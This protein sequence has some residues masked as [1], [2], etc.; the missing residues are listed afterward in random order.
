LGAVIAADSTSAGLFARWMVLFCTLFGLAAMHTIGHTGPGGGIRMDTVMAADIGAQAAVT[1]PMVA[2]APPCSGDHCDGH[3]AMGAG[4]VCVA[5]LQGLVAAMLLT[6]MV[7]AA[8]GGA[9][10]AWAVIAV[11]RTAPRAPPPRRTGLTIASVTV[12]RI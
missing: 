4:E 12:L 6:L 8:L 7:W 2:A 10:R 5:I 1:A 3:G 9:R 11:R